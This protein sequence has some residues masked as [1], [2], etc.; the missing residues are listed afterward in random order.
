MEQLPNPILCMFDQT[1][2]SSEINFSFSFY[3]IPTIRIF[4]LFSSSFFSNR[5]YFS[6]YSVFVSNF[7][8]YTTFFVVGTSGNFS[9]ILVLVAYIDC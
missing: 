8:F 9:S 1:Y 5:V 6:F 4:I 7:S 3:T 2:F